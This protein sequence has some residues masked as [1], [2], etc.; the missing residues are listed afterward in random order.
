VAG[1]ADHPRRQS[2]LGRNGIKRNKLESLYLLSRMISS[3]LLI[4]VLKEKAALSSALRL[5]K[6]CYLQRAGVRMAW[7]R[8]RMRNLCEGSCYEQI[9]K[10][11][12]ERCFTNQWIDGTH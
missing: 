6:F 5:R 1:G 9:K 4:F 11:A 2:G 10:E 3:D 7:Y 12:E 8:G